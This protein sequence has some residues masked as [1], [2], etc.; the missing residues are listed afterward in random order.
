MRRRVGFVLHGNMKHVPAT[1]HE[2]LEQAVERHKG[3]DHLTSVGAAKFP[4]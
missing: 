2:G 4:G 3:E 1:M